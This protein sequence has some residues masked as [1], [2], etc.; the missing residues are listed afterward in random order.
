MSFFP[1]FVSFFILS[2]GEQERFEIIDSKCGGC[3]STD[4]V[5]KTKRSAD[6]WNILLNGMKIRG[7]KVSTDEEKQIKE[8]LYN[9]L[10]K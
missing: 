8:I 10:G 4:V 7:L 3:H 9:R 5:Y 1:V 2:C 6:E